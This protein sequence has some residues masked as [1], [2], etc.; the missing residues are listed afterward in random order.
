MSKPRF[1]LDIFRIRSEA[2]TLSEPAQTQYEQHFNF[3]QPPPPTPEM[4]TWEN[5]SADMSKRHLGMEEE[6]VP[7]V[8]WSEARRL[9][10]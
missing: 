8:S 7:F 10:D 1:E 5:R 2:L 4:I 6:A 9:P 3:I